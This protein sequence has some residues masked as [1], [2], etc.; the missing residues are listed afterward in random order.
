MTLADP[1]NP[2]QKGKV[3]KKV[4]ILQT[5]EIPAIYNPL[6]QGSSQIRLFRNCVE[7][8][9][10]EKTLLTTPIPLLAF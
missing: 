3:P 10:G 6:V 8:F 2:S 9:S 1:F 5:Y 4:W 7:F